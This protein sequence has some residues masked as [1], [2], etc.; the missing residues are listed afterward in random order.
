M[1]REH[2]VH[3]AAVD[4][5]LVAKV[6]APHGCAF[7]MPAREAV[8]PWR[9][10]AHDVLRLRLLPQG[11]V[12]R[13][14][15]LADTSQF[16]A[17]VL[18]ILKRASGQDAIPVLRAGTR[19][20]LIISLDVKIDRTVALIGEAVIHDLLHQLLLLND[21]AGGM[22]LYRGTQHV[23]LVHIVMV[24]VGIVLRYLH[25]FQLLQPGLLGN[26]VLTLVGI[27]LQVTYIRNV[28]DIAHLVAQMLKVTEQQVEGDGRTGMAQMRVTIDCRST[29]IHAHMGC[30]QRLEALHLA[31]QRIINNQF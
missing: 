23:Q 10:P 27:V 4:V 5:E 16:A 14:A 3:A 26:L 8:A 21:V 9:R 19:H 11:K 29:D 6:F 30:M 13:I 7:A 2:Q 22:G 12:G 24:A 1:V 18:D 15:L 20:P 31:R 25:G 17:L 28:A